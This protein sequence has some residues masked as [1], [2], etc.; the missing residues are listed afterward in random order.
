MKAVDVA[1]A[2]APA[3]EPASAPGL[4]PPADQALASPIA[5]AVAALGTEPLSE[6]ALRRHIDPLFKRVLARPGIYLANHSLGRPPDQ[7]A[8]DIAAGVGLWYSGLGDAWGPWLDKQNQVRAMVAHLA[9]VSRSDCILPKTSAGQGLRTVLNLHDEKIRVLS[10]QG[11]FDSIDIILRHYRERGRIELRLI[12]PDARG[13]FAPGAILAALDA[14]TDL[15]VLSQVMFM[16]GQVVG[17]LPAII[18]KAHRQGAR[19]LLDTYHGLGVLPV[20]FASLQVD[21]AVGGGY[22]YLRGGPGSCWLY[23]RPDI[24]DAGGTPLDTGWFAKQAPFNYQR[25][26]PPL[27]AAGG[28]GFL[29]STP[30]VLLPYQAVAGLQLT[31]ALGVARIR[32]YGLASSRHLIDALAAHGVEAEGGREDMGAFVV[33]RHGHAAEI[34]EGLGNSGIKVD[35]RAQYLRL[36]PD[37]L[38]RHAEITDAAAAVARA[39]RAV[40]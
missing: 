15:L 30:P 40:G 3:L 39:C 27:F 23:V 2:G 22:K 34:A 24:V 37:L 9:G 36:T 17:E 12:T 13:W 28:D 6:A 20:D 1:P 38:T 29:E 19:V 18:D 8:L 11:E 21:Y 26:D 35:A 16:T 25:P 32:A 10:T 33:I 4:A 7:T 5:Q 14:P 31:A